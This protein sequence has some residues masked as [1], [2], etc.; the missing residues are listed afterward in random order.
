M[1]V[2]DNTFVLCRLSILE[3]KKNGKNV[4]RK[5]KIKKKLKTCF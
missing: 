3:K 4:I 5:K 2:C 1:Q